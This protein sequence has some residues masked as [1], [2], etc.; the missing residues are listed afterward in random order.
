MVISMNIQNLLD[1]LTF[2]SLFIGML[3]YWTSVSFT[4]LKSGAKIG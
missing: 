1:N 4:S 3:A 2:L